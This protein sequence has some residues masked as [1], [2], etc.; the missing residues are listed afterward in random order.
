M[1]VI[2][3]TRVYYIVASAIKTEG[4]GKRQFCITENGDTSAGAVINWSSGKFFGGFDIHGK[5][6]R[7]QGIDGIHGTEI[8]SPGDGLVGSIHSIYRYTIDHSTGK[9]TEIKC[10]VWNDGAVVQARDP[11]FN[12]CSFHYIADVALSCYRGRDSAFAE[13]DIADRLEMSKLEFANPGSVTKDVECEVYFR[14]VIAKEVCSHG[15][16]GIVVTTGVTGIIP[17]QAQYALIP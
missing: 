5:N 7:N 2:V 1:E 3:A 4:V 10:I 6:I 12:G 9:G 15:I 11:C 13:F 16:D 14:R 17:G 8:Q